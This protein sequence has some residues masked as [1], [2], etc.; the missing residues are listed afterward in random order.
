[1]RPDFALISEWIAQGS[2]VLD[3]GCGEGTL[4]R[5]LRD[6]RGVS[7]YGLEIDDANVVRC[8][9]N[10][11]DVIQSDLDDGLA[12]FFDDASFDYVVMTQT[13]QAMRRPDRLLEEMVRVGRE[14]IV[15]FPNM[16]YWKNRL[17]LAVAGHMPVSR[18]LPY[19][20][21]DTPNIHLCTLQDFE[22][23][24]DEKGLRILQRTVVDAGH[25][26]QALAAVRPNLL[27]EIAVYRFTRA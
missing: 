27:S 1:M 18:A 13:L 15:T 17:Q 22:R 19:T 5:H 11:V 3:L 12:D 2:R 26:E 7:G 21:Y 16:G 9:E 8:L 23:L 25:R 4:L 10:C 20:W 14:G 6:T 24:C